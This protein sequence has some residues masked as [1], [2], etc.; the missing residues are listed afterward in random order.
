MRLRLRLMV[1]SSNQWRQANIGVLRV[2]GLRPRPLRARDARVGA[3]MGIYGYVLCTG[4]K[5]PDDRRNVAENG[6]LRKA[7]VTSYTRRLLHRA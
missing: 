3:G 2:V 1:R 4:T 6:S 7:R 5:K